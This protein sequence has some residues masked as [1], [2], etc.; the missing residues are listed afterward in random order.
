MGILD[1]QLGGRSFIC[2]E[3]LTIA[4]IANGVHAWRWKN[5]DIERPALAHVDA[6][7]E[8]LTQRPAYQ[9]Y[10]MLTLT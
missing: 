6:W 4:D 5:L 3:D 8:R 1:E 2:G 9:E 7:Y 10:V